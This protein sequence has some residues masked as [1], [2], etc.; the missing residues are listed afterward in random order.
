MKLTTRGHYSVKAMLDLTIHRNGPPQSIRAIAL[1][2]NISQHFLEQLLIKLRQAGYIRS[3][4]GVQGGY[5]LA[6]PPAQIS[7]GA[8]LQ[9][10]GD[11]IEPLGKMSRDSDQ[12]EDWV[13]FALWSRVSTY[14]QT[15]L[16]QVS[17]EDLYYDT[18]SRQASQSEE[19]GFIV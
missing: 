12:A 2:Q 15:A 6:K 17:L 13:T 14:V 9:V 4:R 5:L 10:V 8:I 7:L 16:D 3:V 11:G 1:R 18:R 19:G